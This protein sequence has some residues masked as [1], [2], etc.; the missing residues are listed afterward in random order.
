MLHLNINCLI[1]RIDK[2]PVI[3]IKGVHV[4]F[5]FEPY[6]VQ[7]KYMETVIESLENG[8]NAI[9][10]SPTGKNEKKQLFEI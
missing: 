6:P 9:L 4:K 7:R 8:Q 5:P 2:M 1:K 3:E 10:E